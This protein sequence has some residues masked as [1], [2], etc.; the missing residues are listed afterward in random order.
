MRVEG[1]GIWVESKS[2]GYWLSKPRLQALFDSKEW[3]SEMRQ[4]HDLSPRLMIKAL[5]AAGCDFD[6]RVAE[7]Y[8]AGALVSELMRKHGLSHGRVQ[9]ALKGHGI[10]I[11][12]GNHLRRATDEEFVAAFGTGKNDV[13]IAREMNIDR[14]TVSK[15][16]AR[17]TARR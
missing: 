13:Q 16:R 3:L 17:L 7:Q 15:R 14:G 12:P 5:T 9:K 1:D 10:K 8:Q 11:S 2:V 4:V 6:A